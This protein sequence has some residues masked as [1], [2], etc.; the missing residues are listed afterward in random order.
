MTVRWNRRLCRGGAAAAPCGG[1]GR[2]RTSGSGRR[3]AGAAGAEPGHRRR[4]QRDHRGQRQPRRQ[5][6]RRQRRDAWCSAEWTGTLTVD[7]GRA[8]RLTGLGMTLGPQTQTALVDVVHTPPAPAAAFK[9]LPNGSAA[10]LAGER[11]G[12]PGRPCQGRLV[13]V[14]VTDND[15]TPPCVQELRLY[16]KAPPHQRRAS[17]APTSR[18]CRQEEQAGARFSRGRR[19]RLGDADPAGPRAELRPPAA[20]GEPARRLHRTWPA[21]SRMAAA[22]QGGRARAVPRHPLLG[23]L[24]RP[25]APGPAR[26]LGGQELPQL[27]DDRARLHAQRAARVRRPGHAG[28]HGVDRQRDPQRDPVAGRPGRRTRPTASWD[29][30]GTLLRGGRR[31]RPGREPRRAQ[32]AGDAALRPGRR[33]R[34]QPPR[35][36][37][38]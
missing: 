2:R 5:R 1:A 38:G 10:V 8:R 22:D 11:P 19:P 37:T 4:R 33:Q 23:L 18:S 27:G 30:L 28:G 16:G 13:Q 12:V 36:S 29:S 32:A 17:A 15:G 31:R 6:G 35:S 20:L 25:A 7:L 14:Q 3:R 26:R 21:T 34:G 24:G 9:P